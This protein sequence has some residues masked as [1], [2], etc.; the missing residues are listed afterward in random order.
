LTRAGTELFIAADGDERLGFI[1]LAE[2]GFLRSPYVNVLAVA[3]AARSRGVGTELLGF[4]EQHYPNARHLFICVSSFNPRAHALYERLGY[5]RIGEVPD[6]IIDG[7]S[8]H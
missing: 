2:H 8:E 4:A 6:F 3:P 7:H 5:R 1:L